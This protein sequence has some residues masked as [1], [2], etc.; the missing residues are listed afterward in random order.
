MSAFAFLRL[1]EELQLAVIT[2]L[3][4]PTLTSLRLTSTELALLIPASCLARYHAAG[5]RQ[6][7]QDEHALFCLLRASHLNRTTAV[8]TIVHLALPSFPGNVTN[9]QAPPQH[10]QHSHKSG[11][12]LHLPCYSCLRWLYA[13]ETWTFIRY[14]D[15]PDKY[16]ERLR[17]AKENCFSGEMRT[18]FKPPDEAHNMPTARVCIACGL[19]QGFY[20]RGM[21]VAGFQICKSCG[22]PESRLGQHTNFEWRYP[23]TKEVRLCVACRA[24]PEVAQMSELQFRHE[25]FW[26]RYERGMRQAKKARVQEG[27]RQRALLGLR[28]RDDEALLRRVEEAG[29]WCPVMRQFRLCNCHKG[30]DEQSVVEVEMEA[31]SDRS[32]MKHLEWVSYGNNP[33]LSK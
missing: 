27:L 11:S 32:F 8:T 24:A 31:N 17:Q 29:R 21:R 14:G 33:A 3:D 25:L 28:D 16:T 26:D 22:V 9:T 12:L 2:H 7:Q 18:F 10:L 6:V 1:P 23:R 13:R 30:W 15:G 20:T 5:K 4:W 19:R